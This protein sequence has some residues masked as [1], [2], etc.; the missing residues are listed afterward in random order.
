MHPLIQKKSRSQS[1]NCKFSIVIP[2][3]NNLK[4]L[5]LCIRSLRENSTYPH[6]LIVMVNEGSDGTLAWVEAQ[7]DID[8]VYC[9]TNIGICYGLNACRQLVYTSYLLYANDD[10]YFC[11]QWDAK[12]WEAASQ[13]P[14]PWFM[15]SGTMIERSGH[16]PCCVIANYGDSPD[17]FMERELLSDLPRLAR[18]DWMGSTWPPNLVPVELWDLVGGMSVEFSPGM[19]SDPDLSMKLWQAGVRS[20]IGVGECLVYHFGCVSTRRMKKNRGREM[21]LAKW[22]ISSNLFMHNF[23]HLGETPPRIT[24][25][26]HLS[27]LQKCGL[28]FRLF[29]AFL[30]KQDHPQ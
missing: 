3:W 20:F 1:E 13:Q 10:M 15:L 9:P 18:P 23:L 14:S 28:K 5:Q 29:F 21:F 27:F 19:Y 25:E 11:P 26:P 16:N 12:L 6:Q 17:D 30:K 7:E 8:F 2:S 4:Y 22:K 24:P